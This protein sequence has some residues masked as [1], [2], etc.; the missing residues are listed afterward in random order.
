MLI[1]RHGPHYFRTRDRGVVRYLSR[2]TDWL[3][4]RYE[5]RRRAGVALYPAA[6]GVVEIDAL[7]LDYYRA[8]TLTRTGMGHG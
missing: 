7:H 5:V 3:P 2:F 6:V 8:T 1:H 4:A